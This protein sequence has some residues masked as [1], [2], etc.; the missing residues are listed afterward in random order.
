MGVI[1]K[2]PPSAQRFNIRLAPDVL[3]AVDAARERRAGTVSRNTWIAEAVA[4]KLAREQQ[5][6]GSEVKGA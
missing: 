4:E 6:K 3:L 2:K 1:R 5:A